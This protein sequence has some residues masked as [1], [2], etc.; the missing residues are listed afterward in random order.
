S[1]TICS[2]EQRQTPGGGTMH[3]INPIELKG[4]TYVAA[5]G[6]QGNYEVT[7]KRIWGQP[8]GGQVQVKIT[9]HQG[10]PRQ[11]IRMLTVPVG[12]KQHTFT[13]A[14][15][16]GRRT[17]LASVAPLAAQQQVKKEPVQEVSIMTKLRD[18]AHP[19]WASEGSGFAVSAG[20]TAR[21]DSDRPVAR[22]NQPEHL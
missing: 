20:N 8:R 9:E 11:R 1:G 17:T 2:R 19:E 4:V 6:F 7:V 16:E 12:P 18:L 21:P 15:N 3:G 13:V 14:L 5:E 10:T 22:P